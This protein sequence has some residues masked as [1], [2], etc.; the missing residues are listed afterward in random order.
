MRTDLFNASAQQA[1]CPVKGAASYWSIGV[2]GRL[3]ENAAW[4]YVNPLPAASAIKDHI[5]FDWPKM[6]KWMEEEEELHKHARD[7][8]KRVDALP[9]ARHVRS[10]ATSGEPPSGQIDP[11]FT[12]DTNAVHSSGEIERWPPSGTL[13]IANLHKSRADQPNFYAVAAIT[14]RAPLPFLA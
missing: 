12:R 6:D 13:A 11:V 1:D 8:Y 5:A 14:T 9:S 3:A 4:S 2:G 10:Q 7:P